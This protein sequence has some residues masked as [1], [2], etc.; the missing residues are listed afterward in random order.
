[1]RQQ[2]NQILI[3]RKKKKWICLTLLICQLH[4][5][6]RI[7]A[8]RCQFKNQ[9]ISKVGWRKNISKVTLW[10]ICR[11]SRKRRDNPHLVWMYLDH[12]R[13]ECREPLWWWASSLASTILISH[14]LVDQAWCHKT[15]LLQLNLWWWAVAAP[16]NNQIW[17]WAT[18]IWEGCLHKTYKLTWLQWCKTMLAFNSWRRRPR[19]TNNNKTNSSKPSTLTR[20]DL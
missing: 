6:Q 4:R 11:C 18:E 19:W 9:W 3:K 10:K 14:S 20:N 8:N 1:M 2:H 15:N 16:W 12:H 5:S 13:I 7:V 17:W